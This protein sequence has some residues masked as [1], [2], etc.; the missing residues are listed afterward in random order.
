MLLLPVFGFAEHDKQLH[1]TV[2]P[3]L[4][5]PT[6]CCTAVGFTN[7]LHGFALQIEDLHA[8][9]ATFAKLCSLNKSYA[10]VKVG[11]CT[12]IEEL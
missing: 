6:R 5:K 1:K 7:P 8:G 3:L 2:K 10:F 4:T 12:Q 9:G 11:F